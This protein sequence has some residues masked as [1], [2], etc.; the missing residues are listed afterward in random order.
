MHNIIAFLKVELRAL[1]REPISVFFMLVV[2]VILTVVFGGTFGHEK[3]KFGNEILG[4]DTVI[5]INIVFLLANT[6]LMG[7]P[8]T[9]TEIKEQS[10]LKRYITYPIQYRSYFAALFITFALVAT[11]STLLFGGI[12]FIFYGAKYYLTLAQ[13]GLWLIT[14]LLI[15]YIFFGMGFL[16]SLLIK[17][18]RT[19]SMIC[20]GVFMAML[21]SSG[22]VMPLESQ[23]VYVQKAASLLP[24]SHSVTALQMSWIGKSNTTDFTHNVLYLLLAGLMLSVV[25]AV[26][27]IKWDS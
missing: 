4:I 24:M 14:T 13:T 12:A 6:G 25:L 20:S 16:L 23:P 21:F 2:P 22:V 19:A 11:V 3:T 15:M 1:L 8:I 17:S 5:P 7:I 27:R 10:V 9:M 18:S 26:V